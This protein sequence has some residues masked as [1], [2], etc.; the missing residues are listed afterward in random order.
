RLKKSL[1]KILNYFEK[2]KY[3]KEILIANDGSTDNTAKYILQKSQNSKILKLVDCK[4]NLGKGGALREGFAKSKG[5]WVLFMDAD[6][7][8]PLDELDKFWQ[9]T[10]E[11]DVIIGSRKMDG[12]N[13]VKRQSFV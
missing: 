13:V 5:D 6:L 10:N 1:P 9:F 8:T 2:Q 4:I 12:A 3:S 7:S 11:F